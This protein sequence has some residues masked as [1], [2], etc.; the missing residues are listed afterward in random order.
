M[1]F[2]SGRGGARP[3]AGRPKGIRKPIKPES[4]R[5][6]TIGVRLPA[7]MVQWL[8]NHDEAFLELNGQVKNSWHIHTLANTTKINEFL[9]FR[10]C[11][12]KLEKGEIKYCYELNR[13]HEASRRLN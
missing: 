10:V 4:E 8:K 3:N 5:R 7:W 12:R 6:Q 2:K 11:Y 13:S 1:K 9:T